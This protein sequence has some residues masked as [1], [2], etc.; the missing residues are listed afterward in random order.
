MDRSVR[1]NKLFSF[2]KKD[3]DNQIITAILDKSK[4]L[5]SEHIVSLVDF[6]CPDIKTTK[7]YTKL[8][9]GTM[10][11]YSLGAYIMLLISGKKYN[12]YRVLSKI[13]GLNKN[14]FL[15]LLK[16][17]N[18]PKDLN[19][20]IIY[21]SAFNVLIDHVFDSYLKQFD[22]NKRAKIIKLAINSK[23]VDKDKNMVSLLSYLAQ[24]L[25]SKNIKYFEKWCDAEVKSINK[26]MSIRDF[27]VKATMDLLYGTI[28]KQ[29]SKK[30]I[31]L[32]YE[33][34]YFVQMLDD[35]IDLEEDIKNKHMTPVIQNIW[36]YDTIIEQYYKCEKLTCD[37]A[38][39]NNISKKLLPLIKGSVMYLSYNLVKKMGNRSGN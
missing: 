23:S 19:K 18:F 24:N 16:F 27:G 1:L 37:I 30:N 8:R 4:P 9:L 28:S 29:V 21:A 2:F 3:T 15:F 38:I 20:Q 33:V 34:G 7:F 10:E 13:L 17:I 31:K 39:E 25:N 12:K 6:Y 32:M 14:Y 36:N 11:L 26:Q 5:F 22:P 35:Y